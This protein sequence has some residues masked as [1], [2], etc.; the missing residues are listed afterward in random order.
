MRQTPAASHPNAPGRTSPQLRWTL[1]AVGA[2]A[3]LLL[4]A[5]VGRAVL[6]IVTLD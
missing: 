5:V 6:T 2:G 1:I 3:L 4:A